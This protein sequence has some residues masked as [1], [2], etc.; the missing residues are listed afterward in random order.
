M[1]FRLLSLSLLVLA[2]GSPLFAGGAWVPEPGHG[3]VQ[4]GFSRK[5]AHTSWNA[6]GDVIAHSGRFQNHDFRYLYLAGE[7]GLRRGWSADFVVTWLDGRE[8]PDGDLH[9]NEGW[10]DAW[11]GLKYGWGNAA[12]PMA[13]RLEVRTPVLYDISGPYTLELYNSD[14]ELVANS[15][16]WRGLLKHDVTLYWLHSRSLGGG[17][18]WATVEVGYTWRE[19]APAD[20]LP[21]N[22]DAGW[23][24]PWAGLMVKGSVAWRQSLGNDSA[25]RPE[26]RFGSRQ[27]Y[28]FNDASMARGGLSFLLPFGERNRWYAEAGY[29]IWFWGRSARQYEEPFASLSFRF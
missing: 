26:D 24:L 20:Q 15:P 13:L 16:E 4:F 9:Q 12:R 8:G 6:Y 19:G 29:N 11:F 2:T 7:I 23:T 3:N 17:K 25:R 21:V 28:T 10:S 18:G 27:G 22:L 1:L 14:G 5:T